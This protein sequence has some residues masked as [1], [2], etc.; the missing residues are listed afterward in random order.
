MLATLATDEQH[1]PQG[2][3]R[4]GF[5]A[6]TLR[7]RIPAATSSGP[8]SD[9]TKTADGSGIRLPGCAVTSTTRSLKSRLVRPGPSFGE[10]SRSSQN[11]RYFSADPSPLILY[12]ST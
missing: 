3:R 2:N 6:E 8:K 1:H 10:R 9:P 12:V 11:I 7:R 5:H 4:G